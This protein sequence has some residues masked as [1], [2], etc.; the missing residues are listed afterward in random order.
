MALWWAWAISKARPT[1]SSAAWREE[2]KMNELAIFSLL[3]SL[4]FAD[5]VGLMPGGIIVPFYLSLIHI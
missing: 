2:Q 4:I 3:I 1:R 5:V